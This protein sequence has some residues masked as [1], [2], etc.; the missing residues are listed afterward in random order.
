MLRNFD[1]EDAVQGWSKNVESM[2]K[3][4]RSE[5]TKEKSAPAS[6]VERTKARAFL[7]S[8]S[9]AISKTLGANTKKLFGGSS[10]E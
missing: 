5:R 10:E 4:L 9:E 1:D 6:K 8:A 2:D 3:V 7:D